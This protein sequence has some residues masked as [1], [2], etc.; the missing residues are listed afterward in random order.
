MGVPGIGKVHRIMTIAKDHRTFDVVIHSVD[1]S[2]VPIVTHNVSVRGS[3][4]VMKFDMNSDPWLDYHRVYRAKLSSDGNSIDGTWLAGPLKIAMDF[5]RTGPVTL[6]EVTPKR[7]LYVTVDKG[8]K[9]EVLDWGGTGRSVMLLAGQGVTAR[10]F[11]QI[12]PDLIAHYHVYSVTRRGFGN[13]SKPAPTAANYSA[14]RLGRDV[15]TIINTLGIE[16]PILIGHSLAGEELSYIGTHAPDKVAALIYLDA[17]YWYAY[18][19]GLPTP[20]PPTPPPGF[21]P[22]PPVDAAIDGNTEHFKGPINVPIL[23]IFAHPHTQPP[24]AP[25]DRTF[26]DYVGRQIAAF[27]HGLPNA[28]VVVIPN[29]DHFVYNSNKSQVLADINSF[30]ATLPQ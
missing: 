5:H 9:D 29:A 21:G 13:S 20:K 19:P 7:D 4:V 22:I 2:E 10:A 26:E 15:L 24:G 3:D 14:Q 16:K 1:E 12:V 6:H 11:H 18:D 28:K 27:R 8:V 30:I 17:A 25:K 23:A